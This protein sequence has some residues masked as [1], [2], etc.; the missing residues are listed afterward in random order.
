MATDVSLTT[1]SS[2]LLSG[3]IKWSGLGSGTDFSEVVDQLIEIERTHQNRLEIWKSTWEDK[4]TSIEGLNSRLASVQTYTAGMDTVDEFF[5]RTIQSSNE[6]AVLAENDNSARPG[7]H[8]VEVGSD[9]QGRVASIS[10]SATSMIGGDDSSAMVIWVGGSSLSVAYS[11]AW[12]MDELAFQINSADNAADDLLEE[13]V[14]VVDKDRGGDVYK[15][16]I[17]TGMDGGEDHEVRVDDPSNLNMD[18]K[19]I[20]A[21]FE[22]TWLGN[23]S[24]TSTGTYVG[25]ANKTFT[26]AVANHGTI[27]GGSV[28]FNWA[29]NEGN[30]GTL[31]VTSA[32]TDYEIFQGVSVRFTAGTVYKDDSFTINAYVPTLQAAQD[33]G[34]A[35]AEQRVH[36]GFSDLLTSVTSTD[37]TFVYRYAGVETT[38]EVDADTK[39]QGLADAINNDPNNRG[40]TA[41]II[42]D[43]QN[44]STSYHLVLTGNDT[45]A[46]HSIEIV[47]ET[48]DNF[49]GADSTFTTSQ[50]ASNAMLR[51][52]GYPSEDYEYIQRSSNT[53]SDIMDGVVLSLQNA[54]HATLTVS[55]DTAAVQGKIELFVSSIN[56]VLDYL[57]Q[58]T[59]YDNETG[60]SGVMI[61]NYT[62]DIVRSLIGDI[63]YQAVPGLDGDAD[64]Y[65][66]L[67]QI[68]IRTNPDLDGQWIVESSKLTAA[69]TEDFMGV[70]RLFIHDEDH[71]DTLETGSTGVAH[72]LRL[73][74]EEL[75]DSETGIGNV[76]I[77]NYNGIISDIDNKIASEERRI[78]LVRTRLEE[79]FSRLE[80]L[81]GEL[82]GQ[83]DY[84]ESQLEQLPTIG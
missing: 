58:E 3:S 52:D 22:K 56:F 46:E 73:L 34:L 83:S 74:M 16:L 13:V 37:G 21:V 69:L 38:V 42:N 15:R 28:S 68:G 17:I 43:G 19:S 2:E 55:D 47:S 29:D 32:D 5:V 50:K 71:T 41:K 9:I 82:E 4:I 18:Q 60:E 49:D 24:A 76:L 62:Y 7:S 80:T 31:V 79:K 30:S 44:T 1:A 33:V 61:G 12:T 51:V 40:V 57:S 77:E 35:R 11:S 6:A 45:G 26:L 23:S 39:L 20:D 67:S 63:L 10:F 70:A 48:L 53:V 75:T 64:T 54:G 84:I 81:L 36:D 65:T 72:R 59:D 8:S 25:S 27:G 78:A 14:T 66:H